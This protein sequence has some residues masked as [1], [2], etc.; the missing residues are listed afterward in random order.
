M[1]SNRCAPPGSSSTP[2]RASRSCP[3]PTRSA[4]SPAPPS[5]SSPPR[6]PSTTAPTWSP[7]RFPNL[8]A[9]PLPQTNGQVL[10]NF[11]GEVCGGHARRPVPGLVQHRLRRPRPRPRRAGPGRRGRGL[12][13]QQDPPARPAR[14]GARL[15]PAGRLLRA[16]PRRP[17]QVGHRPAERPGPPAGDGPGGLGHRQ[18]R[19]D[20]EAP[21]AQ[22]RDQLARVRSPAPPSR[23]RG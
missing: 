10:R 12:R 15:L 9:L 21:R 1:T 4:T 5:R 19:G 6:P 13:I 17:G 22:G 3:R 11:G 20:H 8:S 18:W 14:R 7:R 16:R 23:R 2:T